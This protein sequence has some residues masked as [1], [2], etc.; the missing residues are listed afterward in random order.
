MNFFTFCYIFLDR[1]TSNW[2]YLSFSINLLLMEVAACLIS[3]LTMQEKLALPEMLVG[4]V[5]TVF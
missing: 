1:E 3:Y 5:T 2:L 4:N